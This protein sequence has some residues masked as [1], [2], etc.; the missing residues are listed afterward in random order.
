M[1]RLGEN[2]CKIICCV[3]GFMYLSVKFSKDAHFVNFV[4]IPAA[5]LWILQLKGVLSILGREETHHLK[6]Q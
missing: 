2:R 3:L 6:T 4:P 1:E 5:V